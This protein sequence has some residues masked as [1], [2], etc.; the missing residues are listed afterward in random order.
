ME[1]A[2][3][4]NKK[5]KIIIVA[6]VVIILIATISYFTPNNGREKVQTE[7]AGP[8]KKLL[9][10]DWLRTDAQYLIR[11]NEVFNDGTLN[12]QYF[13]PNPINVGQGLWEEGDRSLKIVVEL[14]DEYYPGSTYTLYYLTERD[15]LAGEYYQAIEG[16]SFYV[17][18]AR[19]H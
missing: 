7:R 16:L 2:F 9:V 10:G 4:V 17:E 14:R 13:N 11:I 5:K 19:Y 6:A 15:M 18:F 1:K 3:T 12:A 8:D